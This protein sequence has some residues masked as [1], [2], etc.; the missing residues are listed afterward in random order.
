MSKNKEKINFCQNCGA[1]LSKKN[2][3]ITFKNIFFNPKYFCSN[4]CKK[5]WLQNSNHNERALD[6]KYIIR[7]AKE[8]A[9]EIKTLYNELG[10][11][12]IQNNGR[13]KKNKNP[14]LQLTSV[15]HTSRS[16][17]LIELLVL[18]GQY[19]D[20]SEA[21][22]N[23]VREGIKQD[24]HE[25]EFLDKIINYDINNLQLLIASKRNEKSKFLKNFE[26]I[27]VKDSDGSFHEYK[28]I[29]IIEEVDKVE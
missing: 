16:L 29:K 5:N 1:D 10:P 7:K 24:L 22:R 27:T 21:I 3:I 28:V 19:K 20:R 6:E 11:R 18:F 9:L 26:N 8:K 12:N 25:F 2:H 14:N 17:D 23:Y 15:Y 4:N 13:W